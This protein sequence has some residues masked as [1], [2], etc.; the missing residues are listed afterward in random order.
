MANRFDGFSTL[1]L[2]ALVKW[3]GAIGH[4]KS[5][6]QSLIDVL[7]EMYEEGP[8]FDSDRIS[9]VNRAKKFLTSLGDQPNA[10]PPEGWAKWK[11]YE[12]AR[13]ESLVQEDEVVP[14][15]SW[16][17]MKCKSGDYKG[18][19]VAIVELVTTGKNP[20]KTSLFSLGFD[21]DILELVEKFSSSETS[22]SHTYLWVKVHSIESNI[23][24]EV[25][26]VGWKLRIIIFV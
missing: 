11:E 5:K 4:S 3:T 8:P 21:E 17:R 9:S 20:N 18:H 19:D 23:I 22:K 24:G 15:K 6:K 1:Q 25:I 14:L 10:R 26:L 12:T 2:K 13:R 16:Y 7:S